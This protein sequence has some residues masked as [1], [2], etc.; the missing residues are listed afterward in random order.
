[1]DLLKGVACACDTRLFGNN[2][3]TRGLVDCASLPSRI[4]LEELLRR[5][6]LYFVP[7]ESLV[8]DNTL[9]VM[10]GHGSP[11]LITT[12]NT[13]RSSTC[14]DVVTTVHWHHRH[15]QGLWVLDHFRQPTP[16]PT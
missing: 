13:A 11:A 9:P 10:R 1:M 4:Y 7:D 16:T 6:K 14:I 12:L 8:K 3:L 2:V 5:V 15:Q